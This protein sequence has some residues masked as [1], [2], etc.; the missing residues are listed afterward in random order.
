MTPSAK[1]ALVVD[2]DPIQ[3]QIL[4]AF[5]ANYGFA[6]LVAGNGAA[7]SALLREHEDVD[8]ILSDLHM[9]EADGIELIQ[10]MKK[11]ACRV[12]LVVISSAAST[13]VKAAEILATA[14]QINLIG[15]LPKPIDFETLADLLELLPRHESRSL[16]V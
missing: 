6:V 16:P 2:D 10:Q 15:C 4:S 1:R 14:H 5:L 12:P 11:T 9:P 8:L 3:R 13:T 7:A